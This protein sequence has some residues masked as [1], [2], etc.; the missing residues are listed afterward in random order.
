MAFGKKIFL[1]SNTKMNAH[2]YVIAYKKR[3]GIEKVFRTCKQKL[4]IGDCQSTKTKQQ[5]AHIYT[6]FYTFC[7]LEENRFMAKLPNVD[8]LVRRLRDAKIDITTPPKEP[9]NMNIGS[10]A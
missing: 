2:D 1:V 3:W 4:G 6:V 8:T 9:L 10:Y 7:E 5:I